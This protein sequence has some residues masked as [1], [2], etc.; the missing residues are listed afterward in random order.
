MNIFD[1][2]NQ[3]K[4]FIDQQPLPNFYLNPRE[5]WFTKMGKNV[6]FEE[7]GKDS[8]LRPVL[9]LKKNFKRYKKS[10]KNYSFKLSA[11]LPP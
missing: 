7:D 3:D 11:L 6:G 4:Q 2:W 5:I 9:V 8:F 1:V 10:L